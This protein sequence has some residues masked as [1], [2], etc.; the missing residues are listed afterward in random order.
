MKRT[1]NNNNNNKQL[2]LKTHVGQAQGR[3]VV[4][5]RRIVFREVRESQNHLQSADTCPL[6]PTATTTIIE[7]V[8]FNITVCY[9][10]YL[11]NNCVNNIYLK[12]K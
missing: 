6:V 8:N 5:V 1:K 3:L 11:N 7:V 12:K 9:T 10:L 4:G 2:R